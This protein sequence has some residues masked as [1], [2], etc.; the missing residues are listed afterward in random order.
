MIILLGSLILNLPIASKSG[1]SIGYIN[2]I[3]TA[4]SAT[5]VT[6]LVVVDTFSGWTL[7]GQIIIL[8]LIQI[9]GLGFMTI[10]TLFSMLLHRKISY[11]ERMLIAESLSHNTIQGAIMLIKKI[12]IGTIIFESIGATI[13]SIR[14]IKIFGISNGIYKGIFHSVSAFCNAGFDTMGELAQYSSLT[15]LNNDIIINLTMVS[16]I[17]IG[18]IGFFVW[19]DV[20]NNLGKKNK[21]YSL[22]TKIVILMST[23]LLAL[24]FFAY[25]VFEYNNIKTI[26]KFSFLEKILAAFFQSTT[27]RTA[28][29][30][31]IDQGSMTNASKLITMMFMFIGGSPGSTAGGVKTV[32]AAILIL[33]VFSRLRGRKDIEAYGRRLPESIVLEV[34]SIFAISFINLFVATLIISGIEKFSLMEVMFEIISAYGTVGLSLGITGDLTIASKIVL[35]FMMFF[36]RVGIMT[37]AL[38][39]TSRRIRTNSKYRYP[40]GRILV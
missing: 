11:N 14:F 1:T 21:N 4:T 34:L 38:A 13:L 9:G 30:N 39:L 24:G 23:I 6:G 10:A 36:G 16:L 40:E 8:I 37:I 22:H 33:A 31:T 17:I 18:G 5:C 7:F 27:T 20:Y 28:G 2:A 26:G 3:F 32:T 29:F 25:M 19:N 12:L 15:H 35:M